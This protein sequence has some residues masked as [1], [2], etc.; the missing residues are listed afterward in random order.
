M[1]SAIPG[2]YR[3][4]I[5]MAYD[6][7]TFHGWQIQP[8]A[9]TVQ[10]T[11]NRAIGT[12]LGIPVNLVGCGRTDAGVHASH[13]VAHLDLEVQ[14][15]SPANLAYKLNRFLDST[16]SIGRIQE[17]AA[18]AHA[19][20]STISRTYCYLISRSRKPF[21]DHYSWFNDRPFDLDRMNQAA[22]QLMGAHDFTSF[23]RLHSDTTNH[24][25][26]VQEARWIEHDDMLV[27]R[28]KADR[29]LRNMVRAITGTLL[30]IGVGKLNAEDI[31]TVL[32]AGDRQAAGASVPAQGLFLT[33]VLYPENLFDANPVH[34]FNLPGLF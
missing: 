12:L 30:D 34:P 28:I 7:T 22:A 11:L 13:F 33:R 17:V 29:F 16:I 14:L 19:R 24:I 9:I 31:H 1:L 5:E 23:S 32:E 27:F 2:K 10:E 8:N 3:Y 18:D 21:I 15:E 25:C 26:H 20:F 4:F 6:G